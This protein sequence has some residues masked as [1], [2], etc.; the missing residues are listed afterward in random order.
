MTKNLIELRDHHRNLARMFNLLGQ[1]LNMFKEGGRPDCD[2]VEMVL[3][4]LVFGRCQRGIP[5][6]FLGFFWKFL[7]RAHTGRKEID[8]VH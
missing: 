7:D 3:P 5:V 6:V 4:S 2:L 8:N 1:E